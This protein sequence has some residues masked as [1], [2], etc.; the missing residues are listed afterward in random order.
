MGWTELRCGC[1]ILNQGCVISPT[2]PEGHSETN[3]PGGPALPTPKQAQKRAEA[4]DSGRKLKPG[5]YRL[6]KVTCEVEEV[7]DREA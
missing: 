3:R 7:E 6:N 5:H 2:C 1:K 4:R